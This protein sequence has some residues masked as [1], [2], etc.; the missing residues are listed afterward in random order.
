MTI[1]KVI[2]VTTESDK[3]TWPT[4][5][6]QIPKPITAGTRLAKRLIKPMEIYFND[7]AKII[8]IKN[9]ADVVPTSIAFMFRSPM[10]ENISTVPAP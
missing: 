9:I 10:F 4:K 2:P 7:N 5:I 8:E 3:P 6:P 1:P